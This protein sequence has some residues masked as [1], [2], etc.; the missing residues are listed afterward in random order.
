MATTRRFLTGLVCGALLVFAC[1][2]LINR[3]PLVDYAMAPLILDD[4]DGSADA[5]VALGAGVVGPC[6]PNLNSVR[7]ALLAS[8]LWHARR[9][10]MILFTGGPHEQPCKVAQ[11][12]ADVAQLTG[13]PSAAI[14]V[15]TV[16]R[17]THEN[18]EASAPLLRLLGVRRIVA[19]T[20]RLHMRRAQGVFTKLGFA[21]ERAAVPIYEGHENN[22]SM[23]YWGTRET[24]ALAY[25]WM[26]GWVGTGTTV[27]AA[28]HQGT[29]M[30]WPR[31]ES[32]HPEGPIVIL[33]ASYAGSWDLKSISGVE[34]L[35]RG[36]AGQQS[37]EIA[38]RF[39]R[40]VVAARPR[41]VLIWG[42]INDISRS[43]PETMDASLE[44]IR[45]SYARMLA[46]ARAD[47][48]P[49]ALATELTIR[50]PD[51]W[52]EWAVGL[53]GR[54]MGKV[55][56]QDTVNRHVLDMNR[57]LLDFAAKDGVPVLRFQELLSEESGRRRA[58]F[59]Q[60]DGSHVTPAAYAALTAYARPILEEHVAS[61]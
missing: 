58:E 60:P 51:T 48:I 42:F 19:V 32:R 59:I 44:R 15:E 34:V 49:V 53:V 2:W 17:S 29:T 22:V 52:A 8:R 30:S 26:R 6:V 28:G 7:R 36:V 38:E 9:A 35:N 21:V 61:R 57:W 1:R 13:V 39:E 24:A 23:L 40:D 55:S 41:L 20:D 16:S 33:G 11:S 14:R 31:Q 3:T 37:F 4:T 10:P 50:P 56:Y 43:S 27:S 54:L 12:M 47:G 18:G 45:Q 5:I 25:Y 46:M